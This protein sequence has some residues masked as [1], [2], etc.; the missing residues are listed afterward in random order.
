MN[1]SDS[2]MNCTLIAVCVALIAL[3]PGSL[4]WGME[5]G[6]VTGIC[7][8]DHGIANL[9]FIP[10]GMW[11]GFS[12]GTCDTDD[13]L[14]TPLR[15]ATPSY[16]NR[17]LYLSGENEPAHGPGVPL[18]TDDPLPREVADPLTAR[19]Q[20]NGT[21]ETIP[22]KNGPVAQPQETLLLRNFAPEEIPD[23]ELVARIA[24]TDPS[25]R[26]MVDA[27]GELAGVRMAIKRSARANS[28]DGGVFPSLWIRYNG[29]EV[30]V[31]VDPVLQKTIGRT[32]QVPNGA[33]ILEK[34]NRTEIEYNGSVLFTFDPMEAVS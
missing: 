18:T 21:E 8:P 10:A 13:I 15:V 19:A 34:G 33:M 24:L 16:T 31:M 9:Y 22:G 11:T 25:A 26:R 23:P 4:F 29:L 12:Y 27:G 2:K 17:I 20:V 14:T 3:G 6:S 32:V 28:N 30:D 5:N 7:G 1:T